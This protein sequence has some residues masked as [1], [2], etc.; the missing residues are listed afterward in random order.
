MSLRL[1]K[2]AVE[3]I[4]RTEALRRARALQPVPDVARSRAV[5]QAALL[6]EVARRVLEPAQP[7]PPG[8]AG[9]V[10]FPLYRS[11]IEGLIGA[12]VRPAEAPWDAAPPAVVARA[13]PDPEARRQLQALLASPDPSG[14]D[15]QRI[16]RFAES[17]VREASARPCEVDLLLAQRWL[18][19]LL[20][21]VVLALGVVGARAALARPDL[22]KG[23]RFWTSSSW[24][25]CPRD[26]PCT[27]LMFH[28]NEQYAPWVEIDLGAPKVV[29]QIE[30]TNRG[31][32]CSERS[33]PL[34]AELSKDGNKWTEVGRRTKE[35]ASWT[36][37]FSPATARYVR[38]RVPRVTTLH[39]QSI[40]VR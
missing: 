27:V 31:D 35:F 26:P 25:D 22:A 28:T 33:I 7:L 18:R 10:A 23:K 2:R 15:L 38:L 11:A 20:C 14:E 32:C 34:V 9:G 1:H 3:W 17:L 39:L 8:D 5:Q 40:V 21:G 4:F 6:L 12:S 19:M 29:R 36:A 13:E 16:R 37:R 30:V 24:A